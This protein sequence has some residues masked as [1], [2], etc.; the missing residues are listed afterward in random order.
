M[1]QAILNYEQKVRA[2]KCKGIDL[3]VKRN[4]IVDSAKSGIQP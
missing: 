2:V 1:K 3:L 4:T